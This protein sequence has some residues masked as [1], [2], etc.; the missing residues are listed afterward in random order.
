M[1]VGQRG[2]MGYL[3]FFSTPKWGWRTV[4]LS[5]GVS[6]DLHPVIKPDQNRTIKDWRGSPSM[7]RLGS[8]LPLATLLSSGPYHRMNH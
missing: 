2:K 4:Y 5:R 3:K 6:Q 7:F 1:L 8:Q